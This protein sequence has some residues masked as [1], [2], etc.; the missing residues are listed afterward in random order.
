MYITMFYVT[1]RKM[2][3]NNYY[4]LKLLTFQERISM[5][6]P[7]KIIIFL[8]IYT[9]LFLPNLKATPDKN[10]IC[11]ALITVPANYTQIKSYLAEGG[12]LDCKCPVRQKT[13]FISMDQTIVSFYNTK[14]SEYTLQNDGNQ[15]VIIETLEV[16]PLYLAISREDYSLLRFLFINGINF[17]KELE[18]GLLP[19]ELALH[20]N[21][22]KMLFALN[23]YGARMN[24]V[25]IGCPN[26]IYLTKLVIQ[27]GADPMT[28]DLDCGIWDKKRFQEY[29][30]LVPDFTKKQITEIQ[31]NRLF[32]DLPIL[33]Q[34]IIKGLDV[35]QSFP[36]FDEAGN[37]GTKTLLI[38]AVETENEVVVDLLLKYGAYINASSSKDWTPIFYAVKNKQK[39]L[40]KKFI[41]QGANLNTI[42]RNTEQETL[43]GLSV[44][45]EVV[46]ILELLLRS[47]AKPFIENYEKPKLPLVRAFQKQKEKLIN[48]LIKYTDEKDLLITNY[49]TLEK[50]LN[51]P[52]TLDLALSFGLKSPD[53][54]LKQAITN[55]HS[56]IVEVILKN[57]TNWKEKPYQ[58]DNEL[59]PIYQAIQAE[60]TVIATK[61]IT[62][63]IDIQAEIQG[64]NPLLIQAIEQESLILVHQ[65]L[66][67]GA[68]PNTY[69]KSGLSALGLAIELQN[70]EIVRALIN[71]N[72][73]ITCEEV[74]LA[75]I[76]N[77][78]IILTMI[79]KVVGD[80]DCKRSRR[81]RLKTKKL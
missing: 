24:K 70:R 2:K 3:V 19:A 80:F 16:S 1:L 64:E 72:V 63:G 11:Q 31:A 20:D 42:T 39:H 9:L 40:V 22:K 78:L 32:Q 58:N 62:S 54:L 26:D 36:Y 5:K 49:Y 56:E 15:N 66:N 67:H 14:I 13:E 30:D 60:N 10:S 27:L 71:Q 46:D 75:K 65:L 41:R 29:L 23:Q 50:L 48:L 12:K 43:L 74:E 4:F 61:L 28:I 55:N 7:F 59:P 77:D 38:H 69:N 6:S 52:K 76:K 21:R 47:G 57:N 81:K 53:E 51:Q 25:Q 34:L 17:N 8:I 45:I 18:N 68:N 37:Y 44:D 35:N 73:G 33:E 79:K